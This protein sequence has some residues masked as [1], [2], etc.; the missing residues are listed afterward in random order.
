MPTGLLWLMGICNVVN[1]SEI[2]KLAKNPLPYAYLCRKHTRVCVGIQLSSPDNTP[3]LSL[4]CQ[5]KKS[6]KSAQRLL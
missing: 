3:T 4:S 6:T 5:A 1:E 2:F